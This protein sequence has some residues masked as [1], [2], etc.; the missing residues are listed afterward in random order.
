MTAVDF[1]VAGLPI[2]KGS[3]R[4]VGNGR[5]VESAKGLPDWRR[6]IADAA[7]TY[8]LQQEPYTGPLWVETHFY[9]PRPQSHYR[10]NDRTRDLKAN[11]PKY[12]SRKPDIDK[13]A[14]A[15]LDAITDAGLWHDDAQVSWLRAAKDYADDRIPGVRVLIEEAR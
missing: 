9:L 13:L 3:L 5:L 14:R 1:F 6:A 4:H 10:G 11:A 8:R 7:W 2:A 15:V 12:P